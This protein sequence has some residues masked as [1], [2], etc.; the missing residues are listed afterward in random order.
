MKCLSEKFKFGSNAA[1]KELILQKYKEIPIIYSAKIGEKK[2]LETMV[3]Y[4]STENR[5]E[6]QRQIDE[7]L[8]CRRGI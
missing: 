2:L 6:I 3:N 8:A 7:F 1:N 5:K 4:L